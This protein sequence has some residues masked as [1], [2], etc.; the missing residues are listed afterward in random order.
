MSAA[1][2]PPPS[3]VLVQQYNAS[4]TLEQHAVTAGADECRFVDRRTGRAFLARDL[5]RGADVWL[6][7]YDDGAD[8]EYYQHSRTGDKVW[9]LRQIDEAEGLAP[10][11]AAEDHRRYR[12][13]RNSGHESRGNAK[14]PS[15][16]SSSYVVRE[17]GQNEEEDTAVSVCGVGGAKGVLVAELESGGES[18]EVTDSDAAGTLADDNANEDANTNRE[19]KTQKSPRRSAPSSPA[20]TKKR[21]TKIRKIENTNHPEKGATPRVVA[22]GDKMHLG[23]A[24][25]NHANTVLLVHTAS[26]DSMS[27]GTS[28]NKGDQ[29]RPALSPMSRRAHLDLQQTDSGDEK[30]R[31]N[32]K[33]SKKKKKKKKPFSSSKRARSRDPDKPKFDDDGS[34]TFACY[35]FMVFFHG[36]LCESPAAALEASLLV[37]LAILRGLALSLVAVRNGGSARAWGPAKCEFREALVCL[38]AVP[39]LLALIP[40]GLIY[41]GFRTLEDWNMRPLWTVIG[42]V[43]PRRFSTFAKG[44]GA[45][46]ENVALFPR[47]TMDDLPFPEGFGSLTVSATR[48]GG[49]LGF[50]TRRK[51]VRTAGVMQ[52]GST[53]SKYRRVNG[54]VVAGAW[55]AGE[56]IV[57]R[58]NFSSGSGGRR[59]MKKKKGRGRGGGGARMKTKR[60]GVRKNRNKK[61]RRKTAT[62]L[63]ISSGSSGS[64]S[65]SSRSGSSSSSSSSSSSGGSGGDSSTDSEREEESV[66]MNQ[67]RLGAPRDRQLEMTR[68]QAVAVGT[69]SPRQIV[70]HF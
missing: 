2:P 9:T 41:S 47:E 53:P 66:F 17:E 49:R 54:L 57:H 61:G 58:H 23:S 14:S 62:A 46:S 43:D 11:G 15:S 50:G 33:K 67:Y 60:A 35:T 4:Q 18:S 29:P 56:E 36:C 19:W 22:A 68:I 16:S 6:E 25:P 7:Y 20:R 10:R 59:K 37:T 5:P 32:N 51:G 12:S 13:S 38:C 27:P 52:D 64:S 69:P 42:R 28:E 31:K 30:A 40:G 45:D 70:R 34:V 44:Q 8:R 24:R 48:L 3:A 26:K 65:G 55:E 1:C 39:S 63:R 21:G